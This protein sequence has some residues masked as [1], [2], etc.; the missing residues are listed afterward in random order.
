MTTKYVIHEPNKKPIE[1]NS[2]IN[3]PDEP[4]IYDAMEYKDIADYWTAAFIISNGRKM[5][6]VISLNN[7]YRAIQMFSALFLS[8]ISADKSTRAV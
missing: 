7:T 5:L 1:H 4:K 8:M 3:L 6:H 2:I